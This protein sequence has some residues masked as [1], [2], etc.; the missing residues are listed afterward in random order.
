MK[1]TCNVDL[2][3]LEPGGLFTLTSSGGASLEGGFTDNT[4][5]EVEVLMDLYIGGYVGSLM[6]EVAALTRDAVLIKQLE[7]ALIA[8]GKK[9]SYDHESGNG[10]GEDPYLVLYMDKDFLVSLIDKEENHER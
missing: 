5:K 9:V 1:I 8:A 2:A 10:A 4:C 6:G 7:G 3:T